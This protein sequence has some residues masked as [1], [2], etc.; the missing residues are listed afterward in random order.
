MHT[1][2]NTT[3]STHNGDGL[4]RGVSLYYAI[5]HR[6]EVTLNHNLTRKKGEDRNGRERENLGSM[7]TTTN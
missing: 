1:R 2:S 6:E 3:G 7:T 5:W 4:F